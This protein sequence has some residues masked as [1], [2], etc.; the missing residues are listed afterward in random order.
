MTHLSRADVANLAK[1]ARIEM[2]DAELDALTSEFDAILGAVEQVQEISKLDIKP[3][4]HPLPLVN[5]TRPDVVEPSLTPEEAL[6][7]APESE[8]QRFSVPQILGE[9]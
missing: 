6:S 2:T 1:L 3:T 8:N 9:E 5:V 7:G 4:S